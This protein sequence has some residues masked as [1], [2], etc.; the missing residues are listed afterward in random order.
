ME[1]CLGKEMSNKDEIISVLNFELKLKEKVLLLE[2]TEP[3]DNEE[4]TM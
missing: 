2:K 3:K 4:L 1:Q